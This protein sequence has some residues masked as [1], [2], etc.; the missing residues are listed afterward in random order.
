MIFSLVSMVATTMPT[1]SAPWGRRLIGSALASLFWGMA[2]SPSSAQMHPPPEGVV[3]L[4]ASATA[5]V[6]KDW[7]SVTLST[8]RD[9]SDAA[10]VQAA[11]RQALDT[12]LQEARKAAK[13][14][15]VE[16]RTGNFALVPRYSP[17]GSV[18][19]GWQGTAELI[20]EGRD[21]AAIG[22]LI[23]RIRTLTVGR[24]GHGLSRE[25][26]ERTE[27]EV[28]AEAI[29]R[30][31]QKAADVARQFGYKRYVLREVQVSGGEPVLHARDSR[32]QAMAAP[33]EG[34][35]LPIDAGKAT[36]SVNVSGSVQLLN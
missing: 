31:R 4:S 8:T 16:V 12:A 21:T 5:D 23:G 22:Q 10:T 25:L 20:V 28:S 15:Q 34:E 29:A 33:A 9:G 30:Y 14:D 17:R 19:S 18:L 36:V 1:A 26:R 3:T 32:M 11:L 6:P 13:P 2:V 35:P 7:I 24:I 27:T